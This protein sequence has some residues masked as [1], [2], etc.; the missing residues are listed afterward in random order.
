M[1]GHLGAQRRHVEVQPGARRR[2]APPH[3]HG[4]GR[5]SPPDGRHAFRRRARPEMGLPATFDGKDCAVKGTNPNADAYT[6]KN[7]SEHAIRRDRSRWHCRRSTTARATPPPTCSSRRRRSPADVPRRGGA[8]ARRRRR[9]EIRRRGVSGIP[10]LWVARRRVRAVPVRWLSGRALGRVLVQGSRVLSELWRTPNDRACGASG[11]SRHPGCPVRQW[12]L[13]L[14]HRIRYLLAW[15]HD[16]CKVVVRVLLREVLRHLRTRAG[17]RGLRDVRGGAVAIVQR[18]G[19]ALNL[20]VHIHALVLDGVFA[21][22][23]D[24]P[25]RFHAASAVDAADVADVLAAIAPGVQRQFAR[26][27]LRSSRLQR[28]G[29]VRGR[30][31]GATTADGGWPGGAAVASAVG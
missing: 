8:P 16:L 5:W 28:V 3:D 18:F 15:R 7:A 14:P 11:G 25:L 2:R 21:R 1:G 17:E 13:T 19:G 30:V 6:Y 10:D 22:G 31:A 23:N 24:G 9:A 27:A 29:C 26:R 20:N 4:G 12:V